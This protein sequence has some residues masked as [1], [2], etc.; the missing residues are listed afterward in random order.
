MRDSLPRRN[1]SK[2]NSWETA[3]MDSA[4]TNENQ[5][6]PVIFQSLDA[7]GE[8]LAPSMAFRYLIYPITADIDMSTQLMLQKLAGYSE[9]AFIHA[10]PVFDT[11]IEGNLGDIACK[12][13]PDNWP[14]EEL[15]RG[16]LGAQGVAV[17]SPKG[18]WGVLISEEDHCVIGSRRDISSLLRDCFPEEFNNIAGLI[19]T[20]RVYKDHGYSQSWIHALL[21]HLYDKNTAECWWKIY[22]EGEG[23]R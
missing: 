7:F 15:R 13:P 8:P 2:L 16:W 1:R 17:Y 3:R 22:E 12:F 4:S 23:A 21:H 14:Q 19:H 6:A 11:S 5:H 9:E 10:V 18:E 20:L